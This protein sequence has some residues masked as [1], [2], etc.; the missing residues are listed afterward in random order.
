MADLNSEGLTQINASV[1]GL[2]DSIESSSSSLIDTIKEGKS[3][4]ETNYY[5]FIDLFT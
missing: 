2:N 5:G 1:D 4:K 3:K